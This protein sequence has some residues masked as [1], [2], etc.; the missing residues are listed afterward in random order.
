[1]FSPRRGRAALVARCH[2]LLTQR[3]G[4]GLV[5]EP[6]LGELLVARLDLGLHPLGVGFACCLGGL[7]VLGGLGT[8]PLLA[9]QTC[10]HRRR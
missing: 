10:A 2:G 8:Q 3:R 9:P 6:L 5:L 1:M 7:G 4:L